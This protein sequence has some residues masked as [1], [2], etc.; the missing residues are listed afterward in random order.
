M[1]WRIRL[2]VTK[3]T[4]L[5]CDP[6]CSG[7]GVAI[8]RHLRLP[9]ADTHKTGAINVHSWRRRGIQETLPPSL[10]IY[11]EL[12]VAQIF[13]PDPE[14]LPHLWPFSSQIKDT[15]ITFIFTIILNQHKGWA[16]I[17]PQCSKN[18]TFL[19]IAP[20]YYL[21]CFIW[22]AL[23]YSRPTPRAMFF[24]THLTHG[25][26]SFLLHLLS[27]EVLLQAKTRES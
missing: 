5:C 12:T 25:T 7:L 23:N 13:N 3:C 21:L 19:S 14:F 15:H 9:M 6:L 20:S 11:R 24:W 16:D 1:V 10:G 2:P 26:F 17:Y 8:A 22:A 27:P 4:A 18:L